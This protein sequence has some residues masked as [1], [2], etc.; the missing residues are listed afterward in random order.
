MEHLLNREINWADFFSIA[1]GI[2]VLYFALNFAYSWLHKT[3]YSSMLRTNVQNVLRGSLL[4]FEPLAAL[5]LLGAFTLIDPIL[6]GSLVLILLIGGFYYI[7]NYFGGRIILFDSVISVGNRLSVQNMQGVISQIGRL[8]LKLQTNKGLQ[9]VNY[10]TLI[11]D[12]YTLLAGKEVS[13]LYNL[14][15]TTKDEKV[16][17]KSTNELI[18]LWAATP[19][20]DWSFTPELRLSTETPNQFHAQV[21]VREEK[22][23]FDFFSLMNDWGYACKVLKK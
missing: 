13:G 6:H 1:L 7:R 4:V 16:P 20:L 9:F 10:A 19:Y 18:D 11:T 15:F 5:I 21:M 8:G 22:H 3:D 23:L 17:M 12:G 14:K 2:T